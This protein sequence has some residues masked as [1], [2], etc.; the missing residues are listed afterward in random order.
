MCLTRDLLVRFYGALNFSLCTLV[1]HRVMVAFGKP[2]DYFLVEEPWRVYEVLEK[3]V[4]RH[5]AELVKH[6]H[7]LA[8]EKR[9]QRDAGPGFTLSD[10]PGGLGLVYDFSVSHSYVAVAVWEEL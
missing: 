10:G 3:A 7:R 5:S 8:E 6:P 4:G 9:M 1:H 2:F